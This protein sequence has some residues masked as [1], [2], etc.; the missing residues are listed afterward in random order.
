MEANLAI[1]LDLGSATCKAGRAGDD[2]PVLCF[3]SIVGRSESSRAKNAVV[4]DETLL[5]RTLSLKSPIERGIVTDWDDM[6]EIWNYIYQQLADCPSE[7]PVLVTEPALNPRACKEVQAQL[8]FETLDA[9]ALYI[10]LQGVLSLYAAGR[11]AGIS[12]DCGDGVTQVTPIFEGYCV[13]H[14]VDRIDFGGADATNYLS[15]L[16]AKRGYS[17]STPAERRIVCAIKES[18]CQASPHP[19]SHSPPRARDQD[20]LYELPDGRSFAVKHEDMILCPEVLFNPALA[21]RPDLPGLHNMALRSIARCDVD[22]RSAMFA[23]LLLV[24]GS[25]LL[26]GLP[27]RLRQEMAPVS[28]LRHFRPRTFPEGKFM[29]WI[30]GSILASLSTFEKVWITRQ[31]Y[32]EVGPYVVHRELH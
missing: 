13:R 27:E 6:V 3:E 2:A 11:S 25:T 1:V 18:L 26:N 32:D 20:L 22:L 23:N 12:L 9:P 5:D 4:G 15:G 8:L 24:G 31:E 7:T 17:F 28:H 14:A 16:L 10:E 30:G 19:L 21:G 29:A